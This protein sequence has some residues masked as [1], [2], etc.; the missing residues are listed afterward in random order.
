[1]NIIGIMIIINRIVNII[2]LGTKVIMVMS[3]LKIERKGN[4]K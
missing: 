2:I 3:G 1:M 4:L